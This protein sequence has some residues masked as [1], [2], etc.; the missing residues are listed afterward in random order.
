MLKYLKKTKNKLENFLYPEKISAKKILSSKEYAEVFE[1][2][3]HQVYDRTTS[4]RENPISYGSLEID[5]ESKLVS[6]FPPLGVLELDEGYIFGKYGW[7]VGKNNILLPEHSWYGE[8]IKEITIPRRWPVTS[9]LSGVCLSL[10]SEW[11]AVNHGHFLL[12]SLSR[13]HLF[14]E[15]GFSFDDIDYIYCPTPKG[16]L[17]IAIELFKKLSIPLEKCILER[18]KG[19]YADKVIATSFPGVRRNYPD[20]VISF[21]H[22]IND[23][24]QVTPNRRLYISRKNYSRKVE[25][26]DTLLP[27]LYQNN[28]EVYNPEAVGANALKDFAEAS[29]VIGATGAGLANLVFCQ[30]GTKVLE[31]IPSDH[32]HSYFCSLSQAAKLQYGYL[33]GHSTGRREPSL[34]GPS[35]YDF[36]IDEDEFHD[37]LSKTLSLP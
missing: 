27:W 4:E 30:P 33:A 22:E 15:A 35:P 17:S 3:W 34:T 36:L 5:L 26:E 14:L 12:D 16:S 31:L 21:F 7:I 19:L 24:K 8:S 20:W 29:V 6:D 9:H 32:V 10:A 28:F 1:A 11:S 23:Y 37:A 2:N 25:N 18:G 13:I